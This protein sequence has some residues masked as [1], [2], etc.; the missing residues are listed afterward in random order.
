ML[1]ESIENISRNIYKSWVN[2]WASRIIAQL[3]DLSNEG[4]SSSNC[5]SSLSSSPQIDMTILME[6]WKWQIVVYWLTKPII[7]RLPL[8]YHV[9]SN[10]YAYHFEA[11]GI[12]IWWQWMIVDHFQSCNISIPLY[13][14]LPQPANIFTRIIC[15][16]SVTFFATLITFNVSHWLPR[17][18]SEAEFRLVECG[19]PGFILPLL[20]LPWRTWF[21]YQLSF[22]LPWHTM[23]HLVLLSVIIYCKHQINFIHCRPKPGVADDHLNAPLSSCYELH[24][25]RTMMT[26]ISMLVDVCDWWDHLHWAKLDPTIQALF[27][28]TF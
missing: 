20:L 28:K 23:A 5:I 19:A 22:L 17:L 9:G 25:I 11:K 12:Q 24:L 7:H 3:L 6:V 15:V 21:D 1:L 10:E 26:M 16:M 27:D 18:E 2:Y 14:I 13:Q 8:V 4:R